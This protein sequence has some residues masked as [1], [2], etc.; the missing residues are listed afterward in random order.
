[1]NNSQCFI[2]KSS[3]IVKSIL[4]TTHHVKCERCNQYVI[5]E[6][7]NPSV[8]IGVLT[9]EQIANISYWIYHHDNPP[10]I[11][12]N[13]IDNLRNLRTPS[14]GEKAERVML[15]LQKNCP[16]PGQSFEILKSTI[17]EAGC[18]DEA[19]LMYILREY[20][21]KELNYL[22]P[23]TQGKYKI[24]PRGWNYLD[25]LRE[26][27]PESPIVFIAMSFNPDLNT[28]YD[29]AIAV[30][31]RQAGFDPYR[32]DREEHNNKIDD[33][34]IA[35]IRRSRFVVADLTKQSHGVY[36]EAGF[37]LALGLEVIW[38]CNRREIEE[39]KV[40]FDTRQY[41]FIEWEDG[42]WEDLIKRL[43][44][45]IDAIIGHGPLN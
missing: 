1:M 43:K 24:T 37:A 42:A 34:I 13:N 17:Q 28:L 44:D 41:N 12:Q 32:L 8:T 11:D 18:Y 4:F 10:T 5:R 45:R 30:G 14:V 38:L 40:H 9:N 2:C 3:A 25:K 22:D 26:L 16:I 23:A 33:E 21:H 15:L 39:K 29:N 19:E 27:N 6:T 36:F 35:S 31:V 20:L 7:M